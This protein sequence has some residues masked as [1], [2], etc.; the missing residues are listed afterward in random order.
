MN[1]A[2]IEQIKRKKGE[3]VS[4]AEPAGTVHNF[5]IRFTLMKPPHCALINTAKCIFTLP[6]PLCFCHLYQLRYLTK[7]FTLSLSYCDTL[8]FW[9][10]TLYRFLQCLFIP[11]FFRLAFETCTMGS[12]RSISSHDWTQLLVGFVRMIGL[13][14]NFLPQL[15]HQLIIHA[16]HSN[17]GLLN[18]HWSDQL[19]PMTSKKVNPPASQTDYSISKCYN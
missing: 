19:L 10:E 5:L 11:I 3:S 6:N 15:I 8:I 18:I 14:M 7:L 2:A 9:V 1:F 4:K 13:L 17:Y 16:K 12:S